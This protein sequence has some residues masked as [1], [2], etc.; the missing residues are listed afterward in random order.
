MPEFH[1][2]TKLAYRTIKIHFVDDNGVME[3][4]KLIDRKIP[5]K[6]NYLWF[7]EQETR[8]KLDRRFVDEEN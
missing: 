1:Q 3:F 5:P 7:P 6:K 4:G 2:E 8:T